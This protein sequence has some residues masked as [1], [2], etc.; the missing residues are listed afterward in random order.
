MRVCDIGS[1]TGVTGLIAAAFGAFVTLTDQECV[2]FLMEENKSS[3]C[4]NNPNILPENI[5]LKTYNWGDSATHLNPPFD[6]VLVSDC[7]LPKLYPIE[8][9]VQVND[10]IHLI[11]LSNYN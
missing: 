8:P 4:E 3:V 9:L 11:F 2:F 7:I 1:G 6:I 10:N 5:T